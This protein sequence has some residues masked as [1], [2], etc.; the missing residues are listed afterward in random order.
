MEVARLEAADEPELGGNSDVPDDQLRLMFTCCRRRALVAEAQVRAGL[1][2]PSGRHDRP[3]EDRPSV[4]VLGVRADHG[5]NAWCE[6]RGR[7]DTPAFQFRIPSGPLMVWI[8]PGRCS[9]VLYL[10]FQRGVLGVSRGRP[11]APGAVWRGHPPHPHPDH[12]DARRARS[13]GSPGPDVVAPCPAGRGRVDLPT[14]TW[15]SLL[16]EQRSRSLMGC[17]GHCRRWTTSLNCA[18]PVWSNAPANCSAI[19]VRGHRGLRTPRAA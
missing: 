3:P 8:A 13:D 6:P 11:P 17:R 16:N 9:P 12:L 15:R 5:C 2:A 10:L 18:L 7:S 4:D 14:G 19:Q 1:C